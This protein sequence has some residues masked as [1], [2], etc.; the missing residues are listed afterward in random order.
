MKYLSFSGLGFRT[1]IYDAAFYL[2]PH[3]SERVCQINMLPP[4]SWD[5]NKLLSDKQKEI[6]VR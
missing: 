3:T 1:P 2:P 4:V 5:K 6:H